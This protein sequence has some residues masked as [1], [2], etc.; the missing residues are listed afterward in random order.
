MSRLSLCGPVMDWQPVQDLPTSC[1]MTAG[2]GSSPPTILTWIKRVQK[3]DGWI[4][5]VLQMTPIY[6]SSKLNS[7]LSPSSITSCLCKIK[8][9]FTSNFIK[10][11][12]DKT[13]ILLIVIKSTLIKV[14]SFSLTIDR[15]LVSP[16]PQVE[17]LRVILNSTLFIPVPYQ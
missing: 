10:S 17:S 7:I 12:S 9:Q 5:V 13:E 8:Y 16:S 6:H 2:I 3:M 11:N 15:S 1:P 4:Y 14:H